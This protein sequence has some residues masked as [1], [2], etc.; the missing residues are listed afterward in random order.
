[1]N[2]AQ[3]TISF[4]TCTFN[5]EGTLRECLESV[6]MQDYPQEKIEVIVIDGG[7]KD[8]T[9]E[10]AKSFSFCKVHVVKTDGPEEATAVGYNLSTSDLLVNYPSDNVIPD[11]NWIKRMIQPFADNKH[12]FAVETLRYH[13]N[14]DDK[15]LNKYFALFGMNDPVAFYLHK[16]DRAAYF[17]DTWHLDAKADDKGDYYEVKFNELNL[18]TVGANGFIVKREI[19]QKATQDPKQFSHID[20]CVDLLRMGYDTY[21]FVKNDIW[22]KTGEQ[23]GN[24]IKK[25]NKYAKTLYF[26]KKAIRRY[27]LYNPRTDK[28]RLVLYIFFSLTL[29][30]PLIQS[31]KGYVRIKDNA[32][33]L[34]PVV[35]FT[36]TLVYIYTTISSQFDVKK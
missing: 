35:C 24:F 11:K 20:T 30:E 7:S 8:R 36:L 34:H 21:A 29:I 5:S 28:V 2:T 26:H 33:F 12:I 32:W 4:I 23:F 14:K 10:I 17:E 16:R 18:P 13:Y 25:R 31:L 19:M 6:K 27:H 15:P 3:P 22:H 9:I 1:M